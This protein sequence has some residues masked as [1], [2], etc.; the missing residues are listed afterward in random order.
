MGQNVVPL[1]L[2]KAGPLSLPP[3][4]TNWTKLFCLFGVHEM[5]IHAETQWKKEDSSRKAHGPMYILQC[6]ICGT[7]KSKC[8]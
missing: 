4:E 2:N 3:R 6:K 5:K 8:L 1:N 7:V